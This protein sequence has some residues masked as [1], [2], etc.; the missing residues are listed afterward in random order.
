MNNLNVRTIPNEE[1]KECRSDERRLSKKRKRR[2]GLSDTIRDKKRANRFREIEEIEKP[3]ASIREVYPRCRIVR[4]VTQAARPDDLPYLDLL[5][6]AAV[7]VPPARVRLLRP[8]RKNRTHEKSPPR[9]DF[10][11]MASAV[12]ERIP[13]DARVV[14]LV[15][16]SASGKT[17][18]LRRL[19]F[20]A[21]RRWV[22]TPPTSPRGDEGVNVASQFH[23]DV[24]VVSSGVVA[25]L[26]A[27]RE[28]GLNP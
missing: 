16:P 17:A 11:A 20:D 4:D 1:T 3:L 7:S 12:A 2:K 28:P 21:E 27:R 6:E 9:V 22:S 25:S 26:S 15:G 23:R 8:D 14:L 19:N 13:I 18:V 10:D 5:R 24:A